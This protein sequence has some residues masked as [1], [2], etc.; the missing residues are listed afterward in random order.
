MRQR[1]KRDGMRWAVL[2]AACLAGLALMGAEAAKAERGVSDREVV[3]GM[4]NALS[5]PASALGMGMKN[6]AL[7]Y[8]AKINRQ[9]G[10]QGRNVK[11]ISYDDGYEP[12][13]TVAQTNRLI[14]EDKVFALFGYVG[15][16]TAAAILPL[17]N[18]EK[19]PFFGPFTGA[20]F[21]RHPVNR[22]IFNVRASYFDETEAQ[23]RYLTEKRGMKK[24]AVF[25]QN[26]AYGLAGKGGVVKAL[27]KR[28]LSLLAE[29]RYER[30]T[31]EVD[32]GLAEVKKANPDAVIMVGTYKAMAAFIKKAKDQGLEAVFLNVS[33]VGTAALLKELGGA[34]EGVIISQVMPSPLDSSLPLVKEYRK[35]MK[36]ADFGEYD[37]T[38]LEG[39][40]GAAVLVEILKRAGRA[41]TRESFIAAAESL[42][43]NVGGLHLAYRPQDHQAMKKVYLTRIS[44]GRVAPLD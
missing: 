16:P 15:T 14:Q 28:G 1:W 10:I 31:I 3:L 22:N 7:V 32:A 20:E 26:D 38:D 2:S 21:L 25:L 17:I 29:G 44:G 33:F 43:A 11:V 13:R 23:I 8:F 42:E 4:C 6:G 18:R 41:L 36:A 39:Y 5:G 19:I 9:G 35:E 40:M 37:Y 27:K 30:N 34:G 24:I 12:K